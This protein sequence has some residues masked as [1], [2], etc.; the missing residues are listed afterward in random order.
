MFI[1]SDDQN[2]RIES[3]NTHDLQVSSVIGE[4][5]RKAQMRLHSSFRFLSLS[6]SSVIFRENP[7][8]SLS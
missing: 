6:L 4:S 5:E 3:I 2:D 1:A 8:Q 7:I